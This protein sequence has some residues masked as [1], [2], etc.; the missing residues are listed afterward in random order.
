MT[1]LPGG[2]LFAAGALLLALRAGAEPDYLGVFLPS[3]VLTGLGVGL[4]IPAFS[5]AAAAELPA[6][7]IATGI[8]IF[9]CFRQIGAV[10]GIAALVAVIKATG[11]YQGAYILIAVAGLLSAGAALLVRH[12]RQPVL[13]PR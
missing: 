9:T 5:S 1:A 3:A 12:A 7:R 10:V 11:G 8:A 6:D 2:L 13:A 4:S